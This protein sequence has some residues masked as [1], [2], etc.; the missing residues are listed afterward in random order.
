MDTFG[1]YCLFRGEW[2]NYRTGMGNLEEIRLFRN[3]RFLLAARER[4]LTEGKRKGR[5][6]FSAEQCE[7]SNTGKRI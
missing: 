2:S 1:Y 6:F 4:C 5:K 3:T 7:I